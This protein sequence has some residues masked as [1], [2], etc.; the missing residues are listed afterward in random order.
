MKTNHPLGNRIQERLLPPLRGLQRFLRV[1]A[2]GDFLLQQLIGP[3]E[4]GGAFTNA[5][6]ELFM[7][8]FEGGQCLRARALGSIDL[9]SD[10]PRDTFDGEAYQQCRDES[11][12]CVLKGA[13]RDGQRSIKMRKN[14]TEQNGDEGQRQERAQQPRLHGRSNQWLQWK[15]LRPTKQNQGQPQEEKRE[16]RGDSHRPNSSAVE[17][18]GAIQVSEQDHRMDG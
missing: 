16:S 6:F 4:V 5:N 13:V 12:Q 10:P 1:L 2:F 18:W 7:R 14:L 9:R 8:R 17:Q 11:L 15:S 3:C